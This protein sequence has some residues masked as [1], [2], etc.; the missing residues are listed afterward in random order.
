MIN[1]E[2]RKQKGNRQVTCSECRAEFMGVRVTSR[3]CS[4][5]CY[6]RNYEKK[7]RERREFNIYEDR[8]KMLWAVAAN[9][10]NLQELLKEIEELSLHV[11][12]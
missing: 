10:P 8:W 4:K 1:P 5:L 7:A 6:R 11:V 9:R 3:F 12:V 2:V